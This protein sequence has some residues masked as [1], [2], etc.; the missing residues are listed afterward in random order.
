MYCDSPSTLLLPVFPGPVRATPESELSHCM[1][2]K[3]GAKD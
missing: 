1:L 2:P 3:V